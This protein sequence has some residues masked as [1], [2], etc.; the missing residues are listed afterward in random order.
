M[1]KTSKSTAHEVSTVQSNPLANVS[2]AP[3]PASI[4]AP[5]EGWVEPK[6]LG[7]KGRRPRNGLTLAAPGLAAELRAHASALAA[8]LGPKAVDPSQ[9][10]AALDLASGWSKAEDQSVV[11]NTYA[12]AQR[13]ASWDAAVRLLSAMRLGVKFAVARDATFADR[14]PGVAKAFAPVKQRKKAAP[15]TDASPTDKAPKA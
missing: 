6:K 12:R 9:V 8:E 1:S 10:A 15:T 11:F 14:F 5:P 4:T 2:I 3:A 7:R 13:G